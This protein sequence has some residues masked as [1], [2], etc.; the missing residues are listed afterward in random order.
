[1]FETM[2]RM[3][4]LMLFRRKILSYLIK[5]V[6]IIR[7]LKNRQNVLLRCKYPP[8]TLSSGQETRNVI[9]NE[10]RGKILYVMLLHTAFSIRFF[11]IAQEIVSPHPIALSTAVRRNDI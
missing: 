5:R 4:G 1:M 8:I 2:N 9:S 3:N 10:E 7:K 11:A 6:L